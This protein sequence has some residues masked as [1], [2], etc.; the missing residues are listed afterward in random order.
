ML[1]VITSGRCSLIWSR[2]CPGTLPPPLHWPVGMLWERQRL[3]RAEFTFE[4][5]SE[6]TLLCE[7]VSRLLSQTELS[8]K[9]IAEILGFPEQFTFRKYFKTHAG[10][11]PTDFRT[12]NIIRQISA[13]SPRLQMKLFH[14]SSV[15]KIP[16][17]LRK[18]IA[19]YLSCSTIYIK[20]TSGQVSCGE[21]FCQAVFLLYWSFIPQCQGIVSYPYDILEKQTNS[22]E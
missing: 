17:F 3:L 2:L 15:R 16:I 14:N 10:M 7:S 5:G 6:R 18:Y 22:Y 20:F 12:K 8:V 19:N 13:K 11:S 9:E 1:S 21:W 4:S